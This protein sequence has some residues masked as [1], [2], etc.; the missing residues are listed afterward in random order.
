MAKVASEGASADDRTEVRKACLGTWPLPRTRETEAEAAKQRPVRTD[1][2]PIRGRRAEAEA[3]GQRPL[4]FAILVQQRNPAFDGQSRG[5]G[6]DKCHKE[7]AVW[8]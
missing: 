1:G 2:S 7:P 6:P 3:V 8:S 4:A 5:G